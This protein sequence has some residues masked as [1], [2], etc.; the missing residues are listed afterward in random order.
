MNQGGCNISHQILGSLGISGCPSCGNVK[1]YKTEMVVNGIFFAE[2]VTPHRVP[3]DEDSVQWLERSHDKEMDT[4]SPVNDPKYDV[5]SCV[6]VCSVEF[7]NTLKIF[8][9]F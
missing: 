1:V 5:L 8:S 4:A 2:A 9:G 6:C 3:E 7:V